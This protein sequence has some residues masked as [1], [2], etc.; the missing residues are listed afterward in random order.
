MAITGLHHFN[1]R[2]PESDLQVVQAFY[3]E[4]LGLRL[5]PRPAFRSRGAWLYAG[6]RP[7]L[8]LTQM[9]SG[10]IVPP[11]APSSLPAS[12]RERRSALDHIA[13]G[14]GDLDLMRERLER[15]QVEYRMTEVPE[16]GEVQ[17]FLRDPC[18]IG[19]ELIFPLCSP[20]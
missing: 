19:I 10:E 14:C 9:N 18:G 20:A 17:L 8:H 16:T 3:V 11:G 1:L 7:V 2:F 5:G 12:A 4:V 15:L 13:L 6:D